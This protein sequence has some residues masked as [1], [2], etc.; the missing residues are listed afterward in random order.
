MQT[1]ACKFLRATV[2]SLKRQYRPRCVAMQQLH[3]TGKG[4][5]KFSLRTATQDILWLVSSHSFKAERTGNWSSNHQAVRCFRKADNCGV[6]DP[7]LILLATCLLSR[8]EATFYAASAIAVG[9]P[10]FPHQWAGLST[11]AAAFCW[12]RPFSL[13]IAYTIGSRSLGFPAAAAF[14]RPG[15]WRIR[16]HVHG[17]GCIPRTSLVALCMGWWQSSVWSHR[18]KGE[19]KVPSIKPCRLP[20]D[21]FCLS[22]GQ[23]AQT[24]KQRDILGVSQL[25]GKQDH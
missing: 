2:C 6:A 19:K 25:L 21:R 14:P 11:E 3:W 1:D 4:W 23:P 9:A 16:K 24:S 22:L 18:G 8:E 7:V 12:V 10:G 15:A 20:S 13:S 17:A 5:D